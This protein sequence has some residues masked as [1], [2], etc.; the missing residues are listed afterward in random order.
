MAA[1]Y[2]HMSGSVRVGGMYVAQSVLESWG[3]IQ[4]LKML[5]IEKASHSF[6]WL[7]PFNDPWVFPESTVAGLAWLSLSLSH[8]HRCNLRL[9]G[10]VPFSVKTSR[11]TLSESVRR[12]GRRSSSR[13]KEPER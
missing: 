7:L 8:Q 1:T 5:E 12:T 3:C 4:N 13:A 2:V 10:T 11:R 9:T 6:L